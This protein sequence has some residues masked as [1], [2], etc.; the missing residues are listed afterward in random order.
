LHQL[1]ATI[2]AVLLCGCFFEVPVDP[3]PEVSLE[4]RLLGTWRCVPFNS[5]DDEEAATFRVSVARERVYAVVVEAKGEDPERYEAHRSS[6]GEGSVL[7]VRISAPRFPTKGWT[8]A[9]YSF[10][11]PDVVRVQLVK[12]DSVRPASVSST[13]L[14]QAVEAAL[15]ADGFEDYCVCVRAK[16][17][18]TVPSNDELQRTSDA[19]AAGS[20][21]NS[22]FAGHQTATGKHD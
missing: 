13:A 4:S 12:E 9:R 1:V 5:D 14:R 10:L 17:S 6:L 22:V 16:D 3:V 21:L 18:A 15:L 11:L 20:P 19:N 7:N 8:L 2:T